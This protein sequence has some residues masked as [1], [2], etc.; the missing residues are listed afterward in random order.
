M[1]AVLQC[2]TVEGRQM[3]EEL[4]S[5]LVMYCSLGNFQTLVQETLSPLIIG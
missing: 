3:N 2:T 4:Q 1:V 5:P